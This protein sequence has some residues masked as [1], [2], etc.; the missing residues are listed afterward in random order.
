MG[1]ASKPPVAIYKH[2]DAWHWMCRVPSCCRSEWRVT[3][4]EALTDAQQ[5][6]GEHGTFG[7]TRR[8]AQPQSG[9]TS[10]A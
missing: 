8:D 5:H 10:P 1:K 4:R 6:L 3:H 2:A 9:P 7:F